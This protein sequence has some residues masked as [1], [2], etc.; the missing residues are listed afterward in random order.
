MEE[1]NGGILEELN[2]G[3]L[4]QWKIGRKEEWNFG[5]VEERG[6]WFHERIIPVFHRSISK[7]M[8]TT[9]YPSLFQVV[10]LKIEC[11]TGAGEK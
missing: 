2:I 8:R 10:N 11:P 1:W 6:I 5:R 4:E 9:R 3:I 7:I